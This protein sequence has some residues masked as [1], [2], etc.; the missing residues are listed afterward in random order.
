[1]AHKHEGVKKGH[2]EH[3]PVRIMDTTLRDGHQSLLATRM[4]FE[5][6]DPIIELLDSAGFA[7]LEVWGGATFDSTTRFLNEDP[8]ERLAKFKKRTK[9]PLQMLLRGQNLVGYR[10]YADDVVDAFVE[11]SAETG[12]DVFRV[13]DALNDERNM[14]RSYEAIKKTGKHIQGTLCYT[15]TEPRLGGPIYNVEYYIDKAR[16]QVAMGAHSL[17]VK[18]MAG[19]LCPQDAFILIRALKEAVDVP[20][21][22]HTHYTSGMGSM[23]YLKAVEAGVDI[24]DCALAPLAL[25][26]SQPAV[27]PMVMALKGTDRD[28]GLDLA[29]LARAGDLLE[30]IAPKYRDHLDVSTLAQID[31][32]VLIHQIP[33]GMRSNLVSQLKEAGALDRIGEVFKELPETRADMGYPPLVTP[34]SQIVGTQAVMNVLFGRY[35]QVTQPVKD[36]MAGLYGRPPGPVNPEVQQQIL[37]G[38]KYQEQITVRPAD[39]LEPEMDK[40]RAAVKDISTEIGDVLIYAMY[41]TTGMKF[42]RWKYGLETPPAEVMP[43]TIAQCEAEQALVDKARKGLLVEPAGKAP[44]PP[45]SGAIRKFNVFVDGEH[46]EVEVDP[47]GG[48]VNVGAGV[49]V[50]ARPA[51]ADSAPAPAAAPAQAAPAA[52]GAGAVA[53][54]M[55]GVVIEYRVKAGEAVKPG[56]VLLILEAMKMQNEI[57]ATAAGK[58]AEISCRPGDRV[59]KGE[60]LIRLES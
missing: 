43:K 4:R 34:S 38:H 53:A 60:A 18:D 45:R 17:C 44:A 52:A 41:P 13:F 12:I 33:G 37:K 55:P 26:T 8:W 25:R 19:I 42:L 39:L 14:E 32:G 27:E 15:L 28:P 2:L 31:A 7:A 22:L 21:Q 11:K 20:I 50:A 40:A 1:M 29:L 6:M 48:A 10:H 58:V 35:Q 23:T 47:A 57:K 46:F 30:K 56:D 16:V 51:V 36:Y 54:P 24:I 49:S 9:T 5:D 3:R 59:Q